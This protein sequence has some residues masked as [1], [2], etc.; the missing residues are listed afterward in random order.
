VLGK[1]NK[2]TE[3]AL[4]YFNVKVPEELQNVKIQVKDLNYERV[5]PLSGKQSVHFAYH[6]MNENKLR[7]LPIVDDYNNLEGIITMK[8]IAMS[9]INIDQ[10]YLNTSYDNI[11]ET[12]QGTEILSIVIQ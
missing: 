8:D 3:Y 9:L 10:K 6:Y 2:E 11:I 7:T 12:L 5:R 4:N 1:I